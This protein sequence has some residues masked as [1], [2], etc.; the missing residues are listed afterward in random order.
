MST[1]TVEVSGLTC[2]HCVET[3]TNAVSALDDVDAVSVDLQRG[4]NSLVTITHHG[5]DLVAAVA[6]AVQSEGYS[7]EAV[8]EQT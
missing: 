4:G 7:L 6:Q 1:L 5:S 3:V 2:Q 8:T